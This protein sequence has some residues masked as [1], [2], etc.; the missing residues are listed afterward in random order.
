MPVVHAAEPVLLVTSPAALQAAEKSGAGFARWM[1]GETAQSADGVT[2]NQ[3]LMRAPAWRSIIEPLGASLAGIQRRDKQA[4]VG[5]S[6]Y[7]HRLFDARWLA[8]PDAFFE[9]VGVANRM[10]RRP[11]Q[12][13][14]CGETRLVYRLAYRTAEM[15][16]RLPMTINVELRGDAPDANGS[17]ASAAKRWQPPQASMT[18][19]A[20]G[21]WLVSADGPLAPRRLEHERIAQVTTNLQS[22][23]WPSAV[24]PDLGGHAEYMLRAFRW[25]APAKRF[26]VAP[27]ENTPDVAKLK[28]N[29]PLRKELQQWLQQPA[30]LRALDEATLRIPEKFLATEAISVAPRGL[31]RLANRPFAQVFAPGEWQAVAGSR[32]LQSPQAVLRRLDDLSCMGCHQSRAVAGF[33]LLGV[34]RRGASRTFTTGNALAVAHSPHV[35][36]ELARRGT[37]VQASLSTRR[38]DPFRPLAEPDDAGTVAEKPTVGARCEPTRISQSA[39]P[40]L[41]RAE[42]LPRISCEGLFSVCEKTSVGFPGGMC[43][44]PCDPNDR[45]GTC[46]GIAILSDFNSCLAA[47]KPFGECLA[48]HTRPG[49]LRSCSAQQACRDDYICAQAEGQP[50]GRG[51]CIP[52]YFLFQMRVDGHS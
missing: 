8:S 50:E 19:E 37:Y 18:D 14:A 26:D 46:G 32:T 35:Q 1:N 31:E 6:R 42:K 27:L 36:D 28:A 52:P 13:G 3:A 22:V 40:W 30:N 49:N 25:N 51:A 21:R 20:L 17:C 43:S 47:K 45:N 12:D 38:P 4:G 23:R 11:F 7:P 24:R 5:V 2:T 9:L 10:D 39:N 34:D 44:G 15:Q 48:K 33:H 41:D 29:A 16:S